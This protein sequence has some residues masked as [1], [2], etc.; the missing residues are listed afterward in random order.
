MR[1]KS[2]SAGSL[3]GWG[4]RKLKTLLVAWFVGL[5]CILS[6]EEEIGVWPEGLWR[7]L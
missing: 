7:S 2:A 1:H 5:A 6:K 3:D 4:W